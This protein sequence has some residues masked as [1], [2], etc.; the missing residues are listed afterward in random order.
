MASDRRAV[1]ID[2][3]IG[4][5]GSLQVKDWAFGYISLY[6]LQRLELILVIQRCFLCYDLRLCLCLI[7]WLAARD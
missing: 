1:L 2:M 5:F 6:T 3:H 4:P 7:R